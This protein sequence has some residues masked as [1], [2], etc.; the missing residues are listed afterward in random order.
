MR[1]HDHE[2][3]AAKRARRQSTPQK[4]SRDR[5]CD[6]TSRS[7]LDHCIPV[8]CLPTFMFDDRR[9]RRRCHGAALRL[10][11]AQ[12]PWPHEVDGEQR[13]GLPSDKH[14][15]E[16]SRG[17]AIERP[18]ALAVWAFRDPGAGSRH[19][20]HLYLRLF[21]CLSHPPHARLRCSILDSSRRRTPQPPCVCQ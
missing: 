20:Q 6:R 18:D 14:L 7:I 1:W 13:S 15:P 4:G 2:W 16:R 10:I 19:D 5:K 12:W 17:S 21:S 8:K 11:Q 3:H 9:A